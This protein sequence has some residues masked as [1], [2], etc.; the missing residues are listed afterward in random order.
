MPRNKNDATDRHNSVSTSESTFAEGVK[1]SATAGA[2][3]EVE[4]TI[5]PHVHT[6]SHEGYATCVIVAGL[7]TVSFSWLYP[8]N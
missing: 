4:K 6:K 2:S 7:A 5:S 8:L 3:S 1:R